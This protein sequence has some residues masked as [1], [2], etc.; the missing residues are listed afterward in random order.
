MRRRNTSGT[1]PSARQQSPS[2]PPNSP[3]LRPNIN[4]SPS[5]SNT[6]RSPNLS[7]RAKP[8]LQRLSRARLQP[9]RLSRANLLQS[10]KGQSLRPAGK[11]L[12]K[13]KKLTTFLFFS[14]YNPPKQHQWTQPPQVNIDHKKNCWLT[15]AFMKL[16]L[17]LILTNIKKYKS[18]DSIGSQQYQCAALGIN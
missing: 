12:K 15:L 6:N 14:S 9:R 2:K 10:P 7:P 16:L 8:Q 13:L 18:V 17:L 4:Q 3:S 1:C 5:P 11:T